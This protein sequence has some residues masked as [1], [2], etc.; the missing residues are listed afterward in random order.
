MKSSEPTYAALRAHDRRCRAMLADPECA[1]ELLLVGMAMARSVDLGWP[2]PLGPD[3]RL[4]DVAAATYGPVRIYG[5]LA[6]PA[7]PGWQERRYHVGEGPYRRLL[8]VLRSD[9]RRYTPTDSFRVA[10]GRPRVRAEGLCGRPASPNHTKR[11]TD[12]S[13]GGRWWVGACSQTACKA[14]LAAVVAKNRDEC[15]AHSVPVPAANVGGVLERHISEIDW[16]K[17]WRHL[18]D[19]WT[20]PPEA[21]PFRRPTLQLVLGGDVPDVEHVGRRPELVALEGGWR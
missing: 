9:I 1:G 3:Y 12:P 2:A 7:G 11:L 21:E 6:L 8:A 15:A 13:T 4:K 17:L 14:W 20:P 19:T 5:D 18:D 10:C 16:W